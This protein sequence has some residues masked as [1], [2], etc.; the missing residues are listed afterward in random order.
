MMFVMN[1]KTFQN[2]FLTNEPDKDILK[3]QYVLVSTRIRKCDNDYD[4]IISARNYLYPDGD[5][6]YRITDD[7]IR[8]AYF[9]QL[10]NNKP[11]LATLVLGC[12]D[13]GFNVIFM[14]SKSEDKLHYLRYLA[15]YIYY[16]F[17]YPVYEY[18]DYSHNRIK[19]LNYNEKKVKKKCKKILEKA[20]KRE[21]EKNMRTEK[22]R[23]QI[24]NE[25]KE[26]S[27]KE[28]IKELDKRDLYIDGMSKS[29]MVEM[30]EL[31]V[32]K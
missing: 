26:L 11:L 23:N 15:Q 8:D 6:M 7:D 5:V 21:R 14:C 4:N 2:D 18:G 30:Y 28:M 16:T 13:E 25:F 17:D 27:K 20:K 12:I 10:D 31:F 32:L 24:K 22:G 29:E 3:A 19:L 1:S 9:N